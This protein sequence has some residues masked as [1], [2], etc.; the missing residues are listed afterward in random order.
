MRKL[1][2]NIAILINS[3]FHSLRLSRLIKKVA[4]QPVPI[5]FWPSHGA[6]RC[7]SACRRLLPV[8]QT[9]HS[10]LPDRAGLNFMQ[11]G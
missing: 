5:A 7:I 4:T 6:V 11:S 8:I 2:S 10:S 9:D 1:P 3:T